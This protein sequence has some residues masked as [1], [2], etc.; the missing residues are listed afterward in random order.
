MPCLESKRFFEPG[1]EGQRAEESG[2]M[3]VLPCSFKR[4]WCR[5]NAGT[6]YCERTGRHLRRWES[7][8]R[9][10]K[11]YVKPRMAG[12]DNLGL[13]MVYNRKGQK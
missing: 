10:N 13:G 2:G 1:G 5:E 8:E 11:K 3:K 4:T 6:D 7:G 9:S 12:Y